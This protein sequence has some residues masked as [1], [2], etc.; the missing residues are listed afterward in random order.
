MLK[1]LTICLMSVLLN[2][3]VM[4]KAPEFHPSKPGFLNRKG[5]E[6]LL[7]GK[8]FRA[9]SV[10]K[11]DLFSQLLSGEKT[12]EQ[13]AE[14]IKNIAA[15]G[16]R[17][18]RFGAVGFYPFDMALWPNEEYW[19]RMDSLI[20]SAKENHVYLIP[21][22]VWNWYLFTD[23]A[24]ETM[25]DLLTDRDS[26]S[27]Q[28]LELYISQMVNRYKDEPT[29]LFWE[30]GNELNLPAD[31]EF[32]RP[33]GFSDLCATSRGASYMRVRRDNFTTAQMIPFMRDMAKFVRSIDA[34][35][36]ITSGN[37]S[38][39]PAA[40]HLRL[41]KGKGDWT[42][43]TPEEAEKYIRDTNPDPIDIISIHFYPSVDNLRFG[44]KDNDSAKAV[45]ELKRIC[46]RIGKPVFIGESGGQAY[47][48]SPDTVTPFTADLMK[49]V[50]DSEFPI[51]LYWMWGGENPLTFNLNKSPAL[52][53][54]L[55]DADARLR[56]QS[57]GT[58]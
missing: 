3:I 14:D 15:H 34:N 41:A 18:V 8:P 9:V 4:A 22:M 19:K 45:T 23:M 33:L 46:D 56:K 17:V 55:K 31:L 38:P 1:I 49:R 11:F 5:T 37:S 12:R 42:E 2:G 40:Q 35:H 50:V 47:E 27:R 54:L 7:D 24:N 58:K 57:E 20:A 28:Y 25:Q 16:F 29:V 6:L 53:A 21:C 36:L 43:D 32:M 10:C 51:M 39:R 13:T 52:N 26:K 44:N 48:G 30:I